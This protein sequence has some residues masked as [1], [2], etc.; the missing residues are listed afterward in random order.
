MGTGVCVK[1]SDCDSSNGVTIDGGCPSDPADVKCCSKP[2][3]GASP[4]N[5]RWVSDC[6][7]ESVSNQ[8]PGPGSF[9]CCQSAAEGFGGYKDP[10]AITDSKCDD[11]AKAG[12][13]WVVNQFS[14]RIKALGCFRP[15][16]DCAKSDHCCGQA[17]DFMCSDDGGVSALSLSLSNHSSRRSHAITGT[18]V[19]RSRDCRMDHA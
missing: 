11:V 6:A 17:I 5:C 14:G 1:K 15:D 7:G 9:K 10:G 3:C 19:L 16:C 18:H 8:C 13:K 4:G 2:K 12:A